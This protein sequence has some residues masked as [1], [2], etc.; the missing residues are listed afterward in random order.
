MTISSEL[1]ERTS[2]CD[3]FGNPLSPGLAY[4]R[5][6]ILS[7]GEQEFTKLRVAQGHIRDRLHDNGLESIFNLSGLERGLQP[8]LGDT[9]NDEISPALYGERLR[10]LALEH[11]GGDSTEHDIVVCNR[12]SAALFAALMVMVRRGSQVVGLSRTYS[13]PA[14]SRPVALLGADFIDTTELT[15]FERYIAQATKPSVAVVTR[16]PVSYDG[17]LAIEELEKAVAVCQSH[18]V[19]VLVDD[20]GGAR[21]APA[22][23]GQP[24][25]LELGVDAGTTGLDKYGTVGPRLGLLGGRQA[26]VAAIRAVAFEYGLEARPMLYSAVVQSL[27][28]YTE[29]RVRDLTAA[30]ISLGEALQGRLGAAVTRTPVAV[31]VEA[32]ELLAVVLDRAGL[33]TT[34]IVPYEVTAAVAMVLLRDYGILTVHFAGLPPG[35]A[36]LLFKFVP[37]EVIERLGGAPKVAGFVD[38]AIDQ[39]AEMVHDPGSMRELLI[40]TSVIQSSRV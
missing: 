32:E 4:A 27:E 38:S 8:R 12:Q 1:G 11:L 22:V 40:G 21:V 29:Q 6:T 30:T 5:G 28:Q 18:G 26:L 35:T 24:R 10:E 7:S 39:V 15:T 9:Y 37:P 20:A 2:P 33:A 31:K 25:L 17:V 19:P 34:P 3:R 23:W 14:V 13:H 16:L 36:A